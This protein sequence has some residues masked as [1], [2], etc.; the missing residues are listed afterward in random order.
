[1]LSNYLKLQCVQA[2]RTA[3]E[4]SVNSMSAG[5]VTTPG[6]AT[7]TGWTAY[8]HQTHTQDALNR[9]YDDYDANYK[10]V[11]TPGTHGHHIIFKDAG[12][13]GAGKA[14]A[15]GARDILLYAGIN[16]YFDKENLVYAPNF[17]HAGTTIG[18]MYA[19]LRAMFDN[20]SKSKSEVTTKLTNF[21]T[22]WIS[23]D[24]PG[25]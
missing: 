18:Y 11:T 12:A 6:G 5:P 9:T 23:Q 24:L 2:A 22:E 25:M 15:Q 20:G 1:V 8:I 17:G 3:K 13:F 7:L 10:P 4:T 19:E 14:A 21:A 16:P